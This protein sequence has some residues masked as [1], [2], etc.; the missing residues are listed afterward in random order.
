M[1][2]PIVAN[3]VANA[4]N[5]DMTKTQPRY[6][7]WKAHLIV[8]LD[9]GLPV[10][11]LVLKLVNTN[12]ARRISPRQ[13]GLSVTRCKARHRLERGDSAFA[14]AHA[15]PCTARRRSDAQAQENGHAQGGA[16][17]LA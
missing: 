5:T 17:V 1:V 11:A 3:L 9:Q 8:R 2:G 7:R 6:A 10:A 4:T 12:A 14:H 15:T 13:Q 16:R